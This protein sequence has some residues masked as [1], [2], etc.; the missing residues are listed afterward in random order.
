[1][2]EPKKK[3]NGPNRPEE[4]SNGPP[5]IDRLL[6]R[7]ELESLSTLQLIDLIAAK[8]PPRHTS[9][10]DLVY[11][12]ERISSLEEKIGRAHV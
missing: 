3:P 2:A 10:M 4:P 8:L 5:P 6:T 7:E 12:R 9:L 11:L 1:M